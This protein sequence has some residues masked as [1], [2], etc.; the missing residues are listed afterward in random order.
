MTLCE[1]A[2]V[3]NANELAKAIL[4]SRALDGLSKSTSYHCIDFFRLAEW[5][6]FDQMISHAIKTLDQREPYGVLGLVAM[7]PA[8]AAAFFDARQADKLVIEMMGGK[9][10]IIRDK[11]HFHLDKKG[12]CSPTDVWKNASINRDDL[13]QAISVSFEFICVLHSD[14]LG[15]KFELPNYDGSDATVFAQA[16][17]ALLKPKKERIDDD[18]IADTLGLKP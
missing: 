8:R 4:Y 9:L 14:I 1:K 10:Q 17:S 18:W 3:R 5:A 2:I 15:R 13:M 6:M 11:T 7:Q 16:A 12:V